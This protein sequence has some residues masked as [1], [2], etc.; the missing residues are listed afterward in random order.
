LNIANKE[1]ACIIYIADEIAKFCGKDAE[2]MI[3]DIDDRAKKILDI[4][5]N[6]IEWLMNEMI[7]SVEQITGEIEGN[8]V[9]S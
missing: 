2:P 6:E 8:D 1:L 3:F 4:E 7:A 9:I 5:D